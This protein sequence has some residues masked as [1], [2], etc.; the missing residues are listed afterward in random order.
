MSVFCGRFFYLVF[1]LVSTLG[2]FKQSLAANYTADDFKIALVGQFIKNIEWPDQKNK[3]FQIVVV[4]DKTMMK[5]LSVLDG[6]A[7]NGRTLKVIYVDKFRNVNSANLIYLSQ[8]VTSNSD[9]MMAFTRGKGTLVVTEN[10]PSLHNV[11][12]NI[13][14][15]E[16]LSKDGRKVKFQINRPNIVFEN[17]KIKPELILHGGTE[18]DVAG[19]YRETELAMQGLR[20]KYA[21]SQKQLVGQLTR[22]REMRQ[23]TQELTKELED[24]QQQLK[25]NKKKLARQKV[26]LTQSEQKL[27]KLDLD[28]RLAKKQSDKQLKTAQEKLAIAKADIIANHSK[29]NQQ[30]A[31]LSDL[32]DKV[33]IQQKTLAN[34]SQQLERKSMEVESQAEVIDRQDTMI[35]ISTI[36]LLIFV[37]ST[38][39]ISYLLVKNKRIAKEL[40]QTLVDLQNTQEQLIESEKMASLGQLVAGV[41]HEINTPIG[42]VVTSSSAMGDDAKLYLR[43]LREKKLKHYHIDELLNSLISTD[44]MIQSNLDRCARLIQNFKQISSDQVVAENRQ[45]RLLDYVNEIMGALSVMMKRN[46]VQWSVLGDNPVQNV[47]PGLLGQVLNNLVNNAI[48]HAFPTITQRELIVEISQQNDVDVIS[49]KDNGQGMENATKQRIFD[50]FFTTKRGRGGTGLGMNIVYNIVTQ[51][52]GGKIEIESEIGK[53]TTINMKLPHQPDTSEKTVKKTKR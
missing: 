19:L 7:I 44:K 5:V 30:L 28:Y 18:L 13:V 53:G 12:I 22:L 14:E 20:A 52:L 9:N 17:L 6:E 31:L 29:V 42:V 8:N 10:S 46:Q 51:K 47:D 15:V 38:A 4:E 39:S 24:N 50:P 1:V 23:Q 32:E 41:A 36:S 11:M 27:A 43:M 16:K 35:S 48:A 37:L 45:I 25:S 49:V 21:Q 33:Q 26:S 34:K 3:P 40:K 2:I